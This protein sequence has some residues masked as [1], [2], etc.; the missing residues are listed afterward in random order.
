MASLHLDGLSFLRIT[1]TASSWSQHCNVHSFLQGNIGK[2]TKS[3]PLNG[4]IRKQLSNLV[5][6][7][8]STTST[9]HTATLVER[10]VRVDDASE[11]VNDTGVGNSNWRVLRTVDLLCCTSEI[12]D[13][14]TI[15]LVDINTDH[16]LGSSVQNFFGSQ[17][18][19]SDSSINEHWR[20]QGNI[21]QVSSSGNWV[22][23]SKNI[24]FLDLISPVLDGV[25][26]TEAHG[27]QVDWNVRSVGGQVTVFI[28]QRTREVHSFLDIGG[29]RNLLQ[30]SSHIFGDEHEP[31]REHRQQNRINIVQ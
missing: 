16:N 11:S 14:R 3:K 28:E 7:A 2:R 27:S 26:D 4:A 10:N 9:S 20:N 23:G 21:W 22:I 24:T 8:G 6:T 13:R 30:S 12:V 1:V 25:L 17:C 19:Q 5:D 31:I 18:K 29:N 15:F